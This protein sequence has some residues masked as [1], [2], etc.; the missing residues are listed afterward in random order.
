MNTKEKLE[1]LAEKLETA[2]TKLNDF[3][4][5]NK[6]IFKKQKEYKD[7]IKII[8]DHIIN[9][10]AANNMPTFNSRNDMSFALKDRQTF[11]FNE[12][13]M[14][15]M[16]DPNDVQTYKDKVKVETKSIGVKKRKVEENN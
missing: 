10:M 4:E 9:T 3:N 1:Y 7:K 2:K 16:F 6:D 5:E 8:K 11:K 15:E 12:K 13:V 14:N